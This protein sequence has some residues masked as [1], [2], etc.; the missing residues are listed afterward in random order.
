MALDIAAVKEQFEKRIAFEVADKDLPSISYIL[1]SREETLASG[2]VLHASADY[3]LSDK[4]VFRIASQS[5]MFTAICLMQLVERGQVDID[6]PVSQYIPDFNPQ[7][8]FAGKASGSLG[9]DVTLRKLM[10]HTAGLARE[11]QSGHYIDDS[12]PPLA[13]TVDE[14][15]NSVLKNDPSAGIFSYSNAGLATVGSVVERVSGQSYADYLTANILTPLGMSNSTIVINDAIHDALAPAR[16][17]TLDGD[18]PA[19]VF[20]LGGAPAGN[21]YAT[22]PDMARFMTCLLRGGFTPE[23]KSIISP[24]SLSQMWTIIGSRPK[25]YPGLKGYGLGF[26]VSALDGWKSV[27]HGG[28][29]YGFGSQ[30]ALLP[31]AGLGILAISTLDSTNN[32]V[33]QLSESGLRLALAANNMGKSPAP[34]RTYLAI[35]TKQLETLPGH[36]KSQKNNEITEI[37]QRHGQLYLLGDGMPLQIKPKSGNQ[38]GVD[39]RLYGEGSDYDHLDLD[40]STPGTMVWKG[41]DWTRIEHNDDAPVDAEIAP[42]LG[43]YGPDI[44][45]TTLSYRNGE[46][47]CLIEYFCFHTCKPLGDNRFKMVGTLYP[48]ETLELDAVNEDGQRGIRVGPMFLARRF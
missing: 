3:E 25:G 22:L 23:G 47:V 27:G 8:P 26:G 30:F 48:D 14:M 37:I 4:T 7:N 36:Y 18:V 17:W 33:N 21:I 44:N 6:V 11:P 1:I 28:A 35:S 46:L 19:P 42:H 31:H 2:H 15:G 41:Q 10:S 20:D 45:I 40:F 32:I 39:G 43:T 24:A 16:M 13:K 9:E 34:R 29:V 5:K 12:N 38:F